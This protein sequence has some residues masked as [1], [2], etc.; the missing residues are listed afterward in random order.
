MGSTPGR[1]NILLLLMDSVPARRL[2]CY[3]YS[4]PVT[5][6]IDAIAEDGVRFSNAVSTGCMSPPSHASLFTGLFPDRHGVLRKES[7]LGTEIPTLAE[8][9][10]DNGYMTWCISNKLDVGR[11]TGLDRGFTR[12]L[13]RCRRYPWPL[14][15]LHFRFMR[16]TMNLFGAFDDGA[17][18]SH[19]TLLRWIDKSRDAAAPFFA[20]INYSDAHYPYGAPAPFRYR[21]APNE[22]SIT[23]TR[24][25]FRTSLAGEQVSLSGEGIR[26]DDL[27]GMS[28][29]FDGGVAYL[30][31]K[32]G[33]LMSGLDERRILDDTIVVVLADHG[34]YLG[35]RGYIGH[36]IGLYGPVLHIPLIMRWPGG[37]QAGVVEERQIQ[38][39]DLF[40]TLMSLAG[41]S[42]SGLGDLDGVTLMPV[43]E[44]TPYHQDL[45]AFYPDQMM[46]QRGSVKYLRREDGSEELY[47]L[48]ADPD[49]AAN[50]AGVRSD[51]IR[52]FRARLDAILAR[53]DSAVAV[54]GS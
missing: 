34:E 54:T 4:R 24:E 36:G 30:D 35:A 44:K 3:G 26:E 22:F 29:L 21:F 41:L 12:V 37:I 28:D 43:G 51:D 42:W 6:N 20:F 27:Q 45:A 11:E 25:L 49:E 10:T 40:P 9:L 46:V 14:S 52:S 23:R 39:S 7:K 13:E 15:S 8:V 32:I 16:Q 19:K 53:R 31:H 5:P 33:E 1:P 2:G 38:I 17:A 47:D 18:A 50:L 48:D